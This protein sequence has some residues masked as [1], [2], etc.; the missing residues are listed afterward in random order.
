MIPIPN[1]E[2][3]KLQEVLEVSRALAHVGSS[4]TYPNLL[5]TKKLGCCCCWKCQGAKQSFRESW[6]N[7][8]STVVEVGEVEV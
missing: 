7:A 2:D 8:M 5:G 6:E 3:E 4:L 1:D